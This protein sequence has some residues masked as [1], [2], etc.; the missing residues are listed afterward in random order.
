MTS[1]APAM[2][3]RSFR[4]ALAQTSPLPGDVA[5]NVAMIRAARARAATAGADLV[6]FPA[7]ALAGTSSAA[8]LRRPAFL[9][10]CRRAC[11][12]LARETADG[13][14]ALLLGLPWREDAS[15]Y[16]AQALLDGGHL[17]FYAAEGVR[18]GK[19]LPPV[20]QE[21]AYR[22]GFAVMA[23]LFLFATWNDITRLFLGA[24]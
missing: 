3:E 2:T 20:A 17:L 24:Q 10:A 18:G 7:A 14:P 4:L 9:D 13:G 5:G 8:L 22:A 21:W 23:S 19:P 16:A 15:L 12:D 6:L 1:A 11:E